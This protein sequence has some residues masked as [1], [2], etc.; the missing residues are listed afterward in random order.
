MALE[1]LVGSDKFITALVA[2]NPTGGDD[3]REGDDHLRGIKNVLKNSFPNVNGAITLTAAELNA[4]KVSKAGDTMT[5]P[6]TIQNTGA[7]LLTLDRDGSTINATLALTTD[8]GSIFAGQGSAGVFAIGASANLSAG[9]W[10]NVSAAAM[11]VAGAI[12]G[13]AGI[14]SV[15]AVRVAGATQGILGVRDGA[16]SGAT[17]TASADSV[18]IDANGLAGLSILT[19]NNTNGLIYFGDPE[20][21]AQGRI[22]YNHATDALSLYA[23]GVQCLALTDGL[24]TFTGELVIDGLGPTSALS[25]GFRG[26]PQNSKGGAYTAVLSDAGRHIFHPAT[27]A[28]ARTYTIPGN[29][30]V[31]FPVGTMLCFLNENTAGTI[32]I[33][34]VDLMVSIPGALTGNRTLTAPGFAWA[35]KVSTTKWMIFGFNLT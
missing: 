21:A 10:W 35:L 32:T 25:A 17:A 20:G 26:V 7:T 31:A 14:T 18:V 12:A 33:A 13:G 11:T 2:G 28:T 27:D 22:S 23:N 15:G 3:K 16:V 9:N 8:A 19:P 29:A 5:G 24:G 6:L 4:P 34:S 30:T 1:N